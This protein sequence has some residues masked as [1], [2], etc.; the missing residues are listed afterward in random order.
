MSDIL[1]N[2]VHYW[3]HD[4]GSGLISTDSGSSPLNG[5]LNGMGEGSWVDGKINKALAFGG[6]TGERVL[7]PAGVLDVDTNYSIAFWFKKLS[8]KA[9]SAAVGKDDSGT[10]P[11]FLIGHYGGLF[12]FYHTIG[13]H[14]MAMLQYDPWDVGALDADWH[15][16]V[17]VYDG[18]NILLYPDGGAP[19][20]LPCTTMY[21]Y[22]GYG[23]AIG[24]YGSVYDGYTWEGIIDEVRIYHRALS[25]GDVIALFNYTGATTTSTISTSSTSSSTS[26]T[27]STTSSTISSSSS[28]SSTVSTTSSTLSSTVHYQLFQ[29]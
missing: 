6:T 17:C 22:A 14:S 12:R 21:P 16:V 7:V 25:A 19:V 5:N 26:S 20:L 2:L 11:Q 15:H 1:S 27:L 3:K 23:T 4:D 24:G 13:Y 10:Y 18:I 9:G 28:T 8:A 29:V